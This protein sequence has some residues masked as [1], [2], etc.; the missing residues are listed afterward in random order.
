MPHGI[1]NE[2]KKVE[3]KELMIILLVLGFAL[4]LY[5]LMQFVHHRKISWVPFVIG[6]LLV[7]GNGYG[8][9]H[10][11]SK[12]L[13]MQEVQATKVDKI[14]PAGHVGDYKFITTKKTDDGT[15]YTYMTDGKTYQTLVGNTT[16]T[17]KSGSPA[18]LET[19]VTDY[20]VTNFFEQF[21]RWGEPREI[22]KG[23]DYVMTV[24]ENW[25]FVTTEQYEEL[26]QLAQQK[27]NE[28]SKSLDDKMQKE[29]AAATKKNKKFAHDKKAQDA[30]KNKVADAEAKKAKEHLN[31]DVKK[32]LTEWNK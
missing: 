3:D 14:E 12:H 31:E 6:I 11:E 18:Q 32:Q 8:L 27:A 16:M 23:T 30:L 5:T 17:I 29:F 4:L 19:N 22:A 20:Q 15:R 7:A 26:V 21:M 2:R 9:M 10:A 24:P 13:F 28:A 25:Q 1:M